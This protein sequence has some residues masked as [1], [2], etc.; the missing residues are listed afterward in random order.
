MAETDA[1]GKGYIYVQWFS[2]KCS[3]SGLGCR[4]NPFAVFLGMV[5]IQALFYKSFQAISM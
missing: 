2:D 3:I 4:L 5:V 1:S